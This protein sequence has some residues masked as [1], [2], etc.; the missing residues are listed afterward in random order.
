MNEIPKMETSKFKAQQYKRTWRP[1]PVR[2]AHYNVSTKKKTSSNRGLYIATGVAACALMLTVVFSD[3]DIVKNAKNSISNVLNYEINVDDALGRLKFVSDSVAEVFSPQTA[4]MVAPIE[5]T[6]KVGDYDEV[7]GKVVFY[8]AA[9]EDV[10]AVADGIVT[11]VGEIGGLYFVSIDHGQGLQTRIENMES[12]VVE[13]AQPV[14][15][16]DAI[17]VSKGKVDVSL[18]LNGEM[19]DIRNFVETSAK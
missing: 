12:I 2:K 6:I 7:S 18:L 1:L 14:K 13:N 9:E 11:D 3:S 16:G 5:N 10:K 8:G 19:T 4:L 15:Q 17:G